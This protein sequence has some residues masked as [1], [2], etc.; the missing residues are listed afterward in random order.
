MILLY[1]HYF[2]I[3]LL[4]QSCPH[5]NRNKTCPTF[6]SIACYTFCICIFTMVARIKS[7]CAYIKWK[8]LILCSG[9]LKSNAHTL[10]GRVSASNHRIMTSRHVSS[11]VSSADIEPGVLKAKSLLYMWV[12]RAKDDCFVHHFGCFNARRHRIAALVI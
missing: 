9:L 6:I 5:L 4:V 10:S 12:L 3:H 2:Y 11:C 8:H 7:L 1:N